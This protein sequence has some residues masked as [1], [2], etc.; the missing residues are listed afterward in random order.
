MGVHQQQP[1]LQP[2]KTG[3]LQ[4]RHYLHQVV[5]ERAVLVRDARRRGAGPPGRRHIHPDDLIG[6]HSGPAQVLS[7]QCRDPPRVRPDRPDPG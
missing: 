5:P 7:G 3:R 2:E 4:E 6:F 1:L